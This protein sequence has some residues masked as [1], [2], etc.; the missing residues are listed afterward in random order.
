MSQKITNAIQEYQC[1]GCIIGQYPTCY[2][3]GNDEAC[4]KHIP[5]TFG[6]GIGVFYLGM[7]KGFCRLGPF[8]DMKITI[9]K[10]FNDGWGYN[11]IFNIP[12]WKYKD[13][14]GNT[15]VRGLCPRTN[16]PWLH[17]FLTDCIKD[18]NCLEITKLDISKM[19]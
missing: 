10:E 9:F 11:D 19:D 5:G 6:F 18:I 17:I 2:E 16:F 4:I 8:K 12:I 3:K 1:P 13:K 7:P 15:L 14:L